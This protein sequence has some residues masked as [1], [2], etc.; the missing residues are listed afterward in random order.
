MTSPAFPLYSRTIWLFLPETQCDQCDSWWECCCCTGQP[1]K[2]D[3]SS[4]WAR[5]K[6]LEVL[7]LYRYYSY[8]NIRQLKYTVICMSRVILLTLACVPVLL[9]A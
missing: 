2:Q 9:F 3:D 4:Q 7:G 8:V 6:W 5:R 1:H